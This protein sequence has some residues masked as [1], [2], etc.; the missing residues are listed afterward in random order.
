VAGCCRYWRDGPHTRADGEKKGRRWQSRD[1]Q[2]AGWL[3]RRRRIEG[4]GCSAPRRPETLGN[5]M[6]HRRRP[7][8]RWP[9]TSASRTRPDLLL[10]C[11]GGT[12]LTER[13]P[14]A[15]YCGTEVNLTAPRHSLSLLRTLVSLEQLLS[16]HHGTSKPPERERLSRRAPR[17]S[18]R[19]LR[20]HNPV[21]LVLSWRQLRSPSHEASR[22]PRRSVWPAVHGPPLGSGPASNG[23]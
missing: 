11:Q 15:R 13:C 1:A 14:S 6:N 3:E 4:D 12:S 20:S 21:P 5:G 7:Q 23:A 8:Q 2:T 17:L 22:T 18:N 19:S 16:R 10:T 9:G